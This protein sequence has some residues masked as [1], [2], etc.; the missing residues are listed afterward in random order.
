MLAGYISEV[1]GLLNDGQGQFFTD[2][3]LCNYINRARRRI[4]YASNCLRCIPPG[5]Q[6]VP[7]QEQYRFDAW[8]PLIQEVM[9]SAQSVLSCHNISI[10]IG[11]KWFRESSGEWRVS[12]G[13]WKPMWRRLVFTDFQ[14]RLRIY[15]GSFMGS[16]STPGWWAQ[17][18][19]G[20][21]GKVFL[22]PI[23]TM[24]MPFEADVSVIPQPLLTDNDPD[25]LEYPWQDSVAYWAAVMALFQQ[26]RPQD[27]QNMIQMFN[28][29]L[30]V[31]AAAVNPWFTAT[32]YGAARRSA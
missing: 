6:T 28:A 5:L 15:G 13:S 3:Q 30:P 26:Q 20:P 19:D 12:W 1:R 10:G 24:A 16:F 2:A 29:E 11:G 32:G 4:A 18:R 7:G 17:Y 27:A 9:P 22:A 23:P 25:P 21:S 31:A 14:A 8:L